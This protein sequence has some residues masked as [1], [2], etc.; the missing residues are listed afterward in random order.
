MKDA[1]DSAPMM[2]ATATTGLDDDDELVAVAAKVIEWPGVDIE[3]PA[4]RLIVRNVDRDKLLKA[5]AYHQISPE[6]MAQNA[7][8]DEEF[9][10]TLRSWVDN[11][12][13]FTYNPQFQHSFICRQ[14]PLAPG[15]VPHDMPM[16]MKLANMH[17]V[18]DRD[19]VESIDTLETLAARVAG[20]AQGFKRLCDVNGLTAL[21]PP[22]LPVESS[23]HSLAQL[24]TRLCAIEC[25]VQETL[26]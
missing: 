8:D 4:D 9:N 23:V 12:E 16:L 2:L 17:L 19:D 25:Q 18:M 7:L 5:Q 13:I 3:W 6:Y 1:M 21:Q 10:R 14:L 20:K 11:Y 22:A 24:W 26:L 15:R